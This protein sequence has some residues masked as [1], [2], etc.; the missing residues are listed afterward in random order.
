MTIEVVDG[1]H[2]TVLKFLLGSDA[3]VAEHR[4]GELGEE[5]FDQI[6]PGTVLGSEHKLE[7]VGGLL[8]EPGAGLFRDV[9]GMIVEN[10]LDRGARWVSRIKQLEEFDELAAAVTVLDQGMD[11]AG[12]QVDPGQQTDRAVA[13]VFMI[14][15]KAPVAAAGPAPSC[16]SPA[17]PASRR[18][19]RPPPHRSPASSSAA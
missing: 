13:L 18:R 17:R 11:P 14:A 1:G 8:G 4:A 15:G 2:E 5:A 9:R 7:P 16:R 10:Q 3:D 19:R 6:E 12:E